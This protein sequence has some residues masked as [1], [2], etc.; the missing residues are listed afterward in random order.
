MTGCNC[1]NN[2]VIAEDTER[3][4]E[5]RENPINQIKSYQSGTECCQDEGV[6]ELQASAEARAPKIRNKRTKDEIRYDKI[7][8]EQQ[9]LIL[10]SSLM[11]NKALK[12]EV[13][14]LRQTLYRLSLD[15]PDVP[16]VDEVETPSYLADYIE[17]ASRN[18]HDQNDILEQIRI[19]LKDISERLLPLRKIGAV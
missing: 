14:T 19:E 2:E 18:M 10:N 1:N 6:T 12:M 7:L 5:L 13:E 15:V 16:D 11:A 9:N 4:L 3:G 8:S 17:L